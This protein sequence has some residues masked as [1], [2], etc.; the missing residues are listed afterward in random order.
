MKE[1]PGKYISILYRR[2]Q[3]F[4]AQVLK[5]YDITLGEYPILI[6]LNQKDGITQEEIAAERGID[7]SAITRIVKSLLEK[8]FIE[9]KKDKEDLRCNYI[10]LTEKGRE[11]WIPIKRGMEEWNNIM[12]KNIE[13]EEVVKILS[14]MVDN[15]EDYFKES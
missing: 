4:W 9:I 6:T 2:S 15:I 5:E 1:Y 10:Y 8:D 7:K 3:V 13:N 14:Q 11:S 12:S